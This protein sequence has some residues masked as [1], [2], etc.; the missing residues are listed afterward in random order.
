MTNPNQPV[1]SYA[2]TEKSQPRANVNPAV[3]T[4]LA[5]TFDHSPKPEAFRLLFFAHARCFPPCAPQ[6]RGNRYRFNPNFQVQL[7]N[8]DA[9]VRPGSEVSG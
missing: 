5:V 3:W 8:D 6:V 4:Q 2:A 9:Q 1:C 7:G